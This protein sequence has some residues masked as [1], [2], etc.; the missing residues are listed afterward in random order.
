MGKWFVGRTPK[1]GL[2]NSLNLITNWFFIALM[3]NVFEL[4]SERIEQKL[5]FNLAKIILSQEQCNQNGYEELLIKIS[6]VHISMQ[7]Y[8]L[9]LED[10]QAY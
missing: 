1:Q 5:I 6:E 7:L 9:V 8:V 10:I 2:L 4:N 3:L